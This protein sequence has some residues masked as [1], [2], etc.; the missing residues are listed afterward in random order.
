MF[1]LVTI[2]AAACSH[3]TSVA[4]RYLQR[5][6]IMSDPA[7]SRGHYYGT[8]EYPRAGTKLAR[9]IATIT[10][11]SGPEWEQ[12]FGRKRIS[13]AEE[14]SLCPSFMIESYID[15]QGE[16]ACMRLDPNSLLYLSKV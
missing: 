11:R 16:Q 13:D 7:W 1:R 2:S 8:D 6:A 9:E 10:Y 3:P 5:K 4:M 12:R 14:P 15:Y